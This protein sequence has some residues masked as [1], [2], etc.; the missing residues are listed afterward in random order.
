[1][2]EPSK[3]VNHITDLATDERPRKRLAQLLAYSCVS[4]C[5]T[6]WSSDWGM[7]VAE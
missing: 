6:T 4:A 5:S 2:N 7:G 1:M 3:P